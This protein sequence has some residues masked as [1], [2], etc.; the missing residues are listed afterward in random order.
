MSINALVSRVPAAFFGMVLG[1]AGLG[2]AW[3]TA[4]QVWGLPS[5]VGEG[6]MLLAATVWAVLV[7][8][9][10]LKWVLVRSQAVAEF[11]H[12]IQC[13]FIGLI[14]V[15]TMLI[16]GAALPYSRVL[17][18][19]L[20]FVG[21]AYTLAFAVWRT[22]GLW[23]GGRDAVAS[24]PVLYLPTVAGSF[25]TSNLL[26][27][28]GFADWGQLAFGAGLFSWLAIE[29][30]LLNRL[31]MS[32]E[33]AINLRPTLGI[34]LAPAAVG[35]VAYLGISQGLPDALVYALLGYG[36]LQ[37]L[38]LVRLSRWIGEQAFGPS[39]WAF[40]FGAT[41]L[42]LAPLRMIARGADGAVLILAPVLF[43][44]A[45]ALVLV[46]AI[47]TAWLGI[48]TAGEGLSGPISDHPHVLPT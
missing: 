41:A 17:A 45:N 21:A 42:A 43:V 31:L 8:L 20:F 14:G 11:A 26:S 3:R 5:V 40:T 9:Y 37:S 2:A 28:F 23:H 18:M 34:Q 30:V 39:Y 25:V 16:A 19:A 29:S 44:G 6:L 32:P 48:K 13:C 10:G 4:H 7:L 33:M 47:R 24:T 38:V 15:S 46:I 36:L 35:A 22:G 12:P 27:A 1:L